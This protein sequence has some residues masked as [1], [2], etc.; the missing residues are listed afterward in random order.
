MAISHLEAKPVADLARCMLG[1][2]QASVVV[3]Y[4]F[5]SKSTF[6]EISFRNT[7]RVSTVWIQIKPDVL[8]GLIWTQTICKF[9][10]QT[11]LEDEESMSL[12]NK[13]VPRPYFAIALMEECR[14]YHNYSDK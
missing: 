3:C 6:S 1:N 10:Q 8:S 12:G 9:Y 2:F 14:F 11:T 5:F 7:F 4:F 13:E